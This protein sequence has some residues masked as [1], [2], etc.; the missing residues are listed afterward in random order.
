[1]LPVPQRALF[2]TAA[3]FPEGLAVSALRLPLYRLR[4]LLFS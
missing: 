1:M 3:P 4:P 2:R